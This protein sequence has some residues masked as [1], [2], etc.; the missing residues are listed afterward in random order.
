MASG[1]HRWSAH[2]PKTTTLPLLRKTLPPRGSLYNPGRNWKFKGPVFRL[3]FLLPLLNFNC[4]FDSLLVYFHPGYF[5]F[6]IERND[7]MTA[8]ESFIKISTPTPEKSNLIC[9]SKYHS[10]FFFFFSKCSQ[11]KLFVSVSTLNQNLLFWWCCRGAVWVS[12]LQGTTL[13]SL[14]AEAL[15]ST[16][17][18]PPSHSQEHLNQSRVKNV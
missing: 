1:W 14:K 3:T 12:C 8:M 2:G 10:C 6:P 17:S 13:N 9:K 18:P 5:F 15:S 7:I 16:P 4:N 11:S